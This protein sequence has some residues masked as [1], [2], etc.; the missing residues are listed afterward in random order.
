VSQLFP[1]I[2]VAIVLAAETDLA[3]PLERSGLSG[4][5]SAALAIV[6]VLIVL[7]IAG[8]AM[9]LIARRLR[10]GGSVRILLAADRVMT[11]A[12]W[13]ILVNHAS[14]LLLAGWLEVVRRTIGDF[15]LI[16]ELLAMLPA[17]LGAT[18]L[19]W[20][21]YPIDRHIREALLIRR[22]DL[23]KPVYPIPPRGRY[24]LQQVRLHLLLL[25]VPVLLILTAAEGLNFAFAKL[26]PNDLPRWIVDAGTF[27]AGLAVFLC[28]P[29]I[30]RLVLSVRPLADGAARSDLT[31]M[32]ARYRVGVREFLLWRTDGSMMNAAVMGL[33]GPLRY[34]LM[35][36]A[37]L[38]TMNRNEVLAVMAHEIG[39]VRRH[40]MPWLVASL[41]AML[42][43]ATLF[44][45]FVFFLGDWFGLRWPADAARWVEGGATLVA[46]A[47]ALSAFGWISR[48]YERQAD[49]FAVQHLS[50]VADAGDGDQS[51]TRTGNPGGE[52]SRI[53]PDSVLAMQR[54]LGTIARLNS[55]DPYRKS[56]RHGS[57]AWRQSYLASLVGKPIDGLPIDRIIRRIKFAVAVLLVVGGGTTA[58]LELAAPARESDM[59]PPSSTLI[60]A[61]MLDRAVK[62]VRDDAS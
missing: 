43:A 30:A 11:L 45:T 25:L 33:I 62:P 32:C 35:T 20:L 22:L 57:I 3:V 59:S 44:I 49:T 34:V 41:L 14:A 2:V 12:R 16:D 9:Y 37:L 46:A 13:A 10:R 29:L 60:G 31:E 27:A 4:W 47:I 6:P 23:G 51:E 21:H 8:L 19:W 42:V 1:I 39:H 18:A 53:T 24:V 7:A 55:V 38:E 58:G 28:S 40:H 5:E 15:V 48:R 56:W 61:A 50:A 36:D 17:L 52:P 54:A 26:G